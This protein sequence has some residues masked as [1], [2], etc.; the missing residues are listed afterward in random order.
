MKKVLFLSLLVIGLLVLVMPGFAQT[1]STVAWEMVCNGEVQT[2]VAGESL[3]VRCVEETEP[4]PEPPTP[5][6]EPPTP[7]PEPP[8]GP[9]EPYAD[10]PACAT[11]DAREFHTLWNSELGCHYDHTHGDN[12]H[13]LDDIFGTEVFDLMGGEISYPWHTPGENEEIKHKSY[14]W[15]V[16]RDLPCYSQFSEGCLIHV[17]A[18]VHNDLHNVYATHHSSLVE[19][20]VCSEA[21]PTNCG[22]FLVSGHSATGDLMIDN[23]QVLDREEPAGAPRPV[24]LHS[25]T[26]GNRNFAT[27]YPVFS[28][29]LR[30]STE[31]GDMWG[32]YPIPDVPLPAQNA[33]LEFVLLPNNNASRVQLHLV[34]LGFSR[35]NLES[36][37]QV[38]VSNV[39]YRGFLNVH[40]G[41]PDD[42]T[43]IS[44]H[45]APL[46]L[47]N[48]PNIGMF[49]YRGDYREYD[50]FFDGVSSGWLQFPGFAQ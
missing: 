45:C 37:G 12:P 7:T 33:D 44:M 32:Y 19:A 50:I 14:Y 6:P 4:T 38:G 31:I 28:S 18:F 10:A 49:Q 2:T 24:M 39:N 34:G 46:I 25:D 30:V 42:C 21:D 16:R 27:W 15:L 13:E 43:A 1:V 36:I 40:T 5:T 11:H 3:L 35:R 8:T 48:V 17:R 47:E 41:A 29:W 20:W 22:R 23:Q 26:V 9:V